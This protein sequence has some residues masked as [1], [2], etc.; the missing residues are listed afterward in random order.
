MLYFKV[1][2]LF[3]D[4]KTRINKDYSGTSLIRKFVSEKALWGNSLWQVTS[5]RSRIILQYLFPLKRFFSVMTFQFVKMESGAAPVQKTAAARDLIPRSKPSV[6]LPQNYFTVCSVTRK[7]FLP[8][9]LFRFYF[10]S[11]WML[12]ESSGSASTRSWD[13][14]PGSHWTCTWAS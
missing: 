1:L 7:K 9:S 14:K 5:R 3:T 13:M 2:I 10:G 6:N 12:P 11:V 8:R 4:S